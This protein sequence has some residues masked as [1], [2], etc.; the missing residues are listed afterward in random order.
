M[1]C[2]DNNITNPTPIETRSK[3]HTGKD[4]N[5]IASITIKNSTNSIGITIAL[6]TT[7]NDTLDKKAYYSATSDSNKVCFDIF[8]YKLDSNNNDSLVLRYQLSYWG[9]LYNW[10]K[11]DYTKTQSGQLLIPIED[12]INFG[13]CATRGKLI[14]KTYLIHSISKKVYT[15][16]VNT[17]YDF[18][19][20]GLMV[21]NGW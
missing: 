5:N 6:T 21:K 2:S 3:V 16:T 7:I 4:S 15:F 12:L 1:S 19:E 10:Y 20:N 8:V 9:T 18:M 13:H 14:F 17:E 11:F